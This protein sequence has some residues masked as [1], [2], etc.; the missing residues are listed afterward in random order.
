VHLYLISM[1]S[2]FTLAAAGSAQASV[3]IPAPHETNLYDLVREGESN[4]AGPDPPTNA[5]I[6]LQATNVVRNGASFTVPV[7]TSGG[8]G[9]AFPSVPLGAGLGTLPLPDF[10]TQYTGAWQWDTWRKVQ[11]V[12]A[13]R[14]ASLIG[15][16]ANGSVPGNTVFVADGNQSGFKDASASGRRVRSTA[17]NA[18]GSSSTITLTLTAPANLL[19]R[20]GSDIAVA[21]SGDA[22]PLPAAGEP[23][24]ATAPPTPPY[25]Y[26]PQPSRE[27]KSTNLVAAGFS[28]ALSA[29]GTA[30]LVYRPVPLTNIQFGGGRRQPFS[31][32]TD[33]AAVVDAKLMAMTLPIDIQVN[34]IQADSTGT[35][36]PASVT[37]N[38]AATRF[39]TSV[40]AAANAGR[41]EQPIETFQVGPFK[42]PYNPGAPVTSVADPVR[43]NIMAGVGPLGNALA[44]PYYDL[45]PP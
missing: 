27:A 3:V 17:A 34:A 5:I 29:S 31:M 28:S 45:R 7:A 37:S 43:G 16:I 39:D 6:A 40:H 33:E 30:T 22:Q 10:T 32:P 19:E 15:T 20:V 26:A 35:L 41:S 25:Q 36:L 13:A 8:A 38:A 14:I 4:V 44:V 9:T 11:A 12:G 23:P 2:I 42:G 1:T 21:P 24:S 18:F